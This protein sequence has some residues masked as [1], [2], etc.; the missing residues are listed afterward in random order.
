[1]S[2]FFGYT[3]YFGWEFE[4]VLILMLFGPPI[5]SLCLMIF[6]V[7]T[8]EKKRGVISLALSLMIGIA[9]YFLLSE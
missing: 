6:G 9:Y 8:I 5:L 3:P 2:N 1:M 7:A 4:I